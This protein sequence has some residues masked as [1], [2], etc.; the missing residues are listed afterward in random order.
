MQGTMRKC[1]D[2][3]F[4]TGIVLR[5]Y[6]SFEQKKIIAI[7]DGC[8]R[9]VYNELVALNTERYHLEKTAPFVPA[10]RER[11]DYVDSILRNEDHALPACLK[12]KL[13]FLYEKEVDSLAIDNAIKNYNSAWE[14]FRT[15]P[16]SGV[17]KYKKKSYELSYQTNAHYR[18]DATCINDANVRFEDKDHIL[19]PKLGRIRIKG[20]RKRIEAL[21][22]RE[23][24][25]IGTITVS[26]DAV[27][28]YFISLQIS[29]ET[30]FVDPLPKT[31][32]AVAGDL[33][34]ENFLWDSNNVTVEN[35]KYRRKEQNRIEELQRSMARKSLQAA[36]DGRKLSESKNYQKDRKALA[37]LQGRIARRGEDFR[38]VISKGYVENQDYIFFEDLKVSN[39]LKDHSLAMAI[40]ECGWSDFLD[41]LEYKAE[42]YGKVFMRVPPALTTQT[43]SKCGYVLDKD[44]RLTLGDREWTCPE[45]GAY[46]VR[47]YNAARNILEKGLA[48]FTVDSV[49]V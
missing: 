21:M 29:G 14:H 28:R 31:G 8:R 4:H 3:P 36:K 10:D 25:R 37:L 16:G 18:K 34:I 39:L 20:S 44:E 22:G 13:P 45:C 33:N 24:T 46:H 6:P 48:A 38:H 26:R 30:S 35:P 32:T 17:P 15:V 7:N 49:N 27:G 42:M 23:G 11:L 40:S 19:L 12:N 47:D 9:A 2:M 5:V 1:K 43:C 41:K